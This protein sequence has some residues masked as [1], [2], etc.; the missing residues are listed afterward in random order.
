MC[1][2]PRPAHTHTHTPHRSTLGRDEAQRGKR[3]V[4]SH[5]ERVWLPMKAQC[6]H[7]HR[8]RDVASF[9]VEWERPGASAFSSEW[10]RPPP[11]AHHQWDPLAPSH[12]SPCRKEV[13]LHPHR[14]HTRNSDESPRPSKHWKTTTPARRPPHLRPLTRAVEVKAESQ[15]GQKSSYMMRNKDSSP[16]GLTG[17]CMWASGV[18]AAASH[19]RRKQEEAVCFTS[20]EP[21][22]CTLKI[23]K[24]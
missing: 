13:G 23:S 3:L 8:G 5:A 1:Q 7:P 24:H 21:L 2:C 14:T 16:W 19:A 4:L 10:G 6:F 18:V 22:Q 12:P 11:T 15:R 20:A 17:V 9:T